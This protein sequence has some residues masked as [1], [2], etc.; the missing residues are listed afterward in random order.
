MTREWSLR[1]LGELIDGLTAGVSVRSSP[2]TTSGPSVLKTSSVVGGR[3]LPEEVKAI[4]P[5]DIHRARGQITADSIII[6]RMN[7]PSLV[8]QVAYVAAH[9]PSKFLPDRLWLAREKHRSD[10]DMKWLTYYFASDSG[11]RQLRELATGT[12]GSMKNIPKS[13]MLRLEIS[14]PLPA[15]QRAISSEL[16]AVDELIFALE[17]L[18]LKKQAVRRCLA[19][20]LLTSRTRLPKFDS[21]WATYCVSD[22]GKVLAGKALSATGRGVARP[23]LRT[24]N[25]LDGR[26]DVSDV[27]QMPMTDAEFEHFGLKRGDVLL[28]E[29]QSLELVGR[30]SLYDGEFGAPCAMQNQLLRFRSYEQTCPEFAAHLFR[31]CQESGVFASIATQTTSVA[32]LGSSRFGNLRLLWPTDRHEQSAIAHVLND[33][34]SEISA[35]LARI[36]KTCC[37]KQGL[38]QQLLTGRTRLPQ[39][40]DS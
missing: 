18:V 30:C 20:Q 32:H 7:T 1:R 13:R 26:I 29:G 40:A 33:A 3:F 14:T 28:N 27:L 21:I 23:Y 36:T 25:V 34:D 19:Q 37:I 11:S 31:H 12:S 15:E 24:K 22:V 9:H 39:V 5:A 10:T 16:A 38:M 17:R 35:L 4:L 8:G 6:S 2:Q